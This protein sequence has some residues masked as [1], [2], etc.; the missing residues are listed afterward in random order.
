[1]IFKLFDYKFFLF[2]FAILA[3]FVASLFVVFLEREA[4]FLVFT[5]IRFAIM[6]SY[7]TKIIIKATQ[8]LR[9]KIILIKKYT[10]LKIN[11]LNKKYIF[12]ELY[13]RQQ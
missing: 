5:A 12:I 6:H 2:L 1:V 7:Y 10:A 13:K 3:F 8:L 4:L 11:F 9:N